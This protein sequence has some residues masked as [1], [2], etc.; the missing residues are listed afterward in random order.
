MAV[1][2][3]T[4]TQSRCCADK[5]VADIVIFGGRFASVRRAPTDRVL[6]GAR[7]DVS[8]VGD[9][10][11]PITLAAKDAAEVHCQNGK[12]DAFSCKVFALSYPSRRTVRL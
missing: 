12:E 4:A 10:E 11:P 6:G 3:H 8:V 5:M 7:R 2:P 1:A 9:V